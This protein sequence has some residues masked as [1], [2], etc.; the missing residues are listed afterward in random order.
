MTNVLSVKDLHVK[1]IATELWLNPYCMKNIILLRMILQ[2]A[3]NPGEF[4]YYLH[5]MR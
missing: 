3:S 5:G 1:Y 2:M 4:G